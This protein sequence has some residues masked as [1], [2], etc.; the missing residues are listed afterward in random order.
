MPARTVT[1]VC[2]WTY[3]Q[4]QSKNTLKLAMSLVPCA[5]RLCTLLTASSHLSAPSGDIEGLRWHHCDNIGACEVELVLDN[6]KYLRNIRLFEPF[7]ARTFTIAL[8]RH[9]GVAKW[10]ATSET[11]HKSQFP[12]AL[13]LTTRSSRLNMTGEEPEGK[14]N[15][16][17]SF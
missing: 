12:R 15:H 7:K 9:I 4:V 2:D 16:H 14:R 13:L 10:H 8:F 17:F 3:P 1:A 5:S 6:N 11:M